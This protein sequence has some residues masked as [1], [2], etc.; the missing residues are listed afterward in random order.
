MIKTPFYSYVERK[1]CLVMEADTIHY[2][3]HVKK[4]S[5]CQKSQGSICETR[6]GPNR[7]QT[8]RGMVADFKYILFENRYFGLFWPIFQLPIGCF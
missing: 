8:R 1:I 2:I 3:I 7:P 5:I 4:L 6:A